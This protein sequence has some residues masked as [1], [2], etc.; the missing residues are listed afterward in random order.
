MTVGRKTLL[1]L[2]KWITA[3]LAA[4]FVIVLVRPD[5]L[6]ARRESPM[7][8]VQPSAALS[9]DSF[10]TAV[11]A[12]GPAVVNV[13]TARVI[14]ETTRP[15]GFDSL[16]TEEWP[17]VRRRVEASLGSGV[18][19]DAAGLVVT[20]HHVIDGAR[21]IRV[22]LSDGRIAVPEIVGADPETDLALLRVALTDLPVMPLGRSDG[23][24]VGDI[25]L[26][27]GNPLG[28]TQTVTQGI[29][30]ATGRGQI[31]TATFADFIQT[32]AA[33]NLGNSGGALVN[34]RGELVG[35]NTAILGRT[36]GTE[37]IGF[38]IPVNLVRG[39]VRE[40]LEHGRVRRGW[41][42]V[43]PRELPRERAAAIG[44][45]S[46]SGIELA[47]VYRN[48]PAYRGGLRPGDVITHLDGQ[49]IRNARDALSRVAGTQPGREVHVQGRRG[50]N[51]L[52]LTITV[53]ERPAPSRVRGG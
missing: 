42:G 13:Y 11:A 40:L 14:T 34:T 53:E 47:D 26:A 17:S 35:I 46:G 51:E 24:R 45:E 49:P 16:P 41:F 29:V 31:G 15:P 19:V 37:G 36:L 10:A 9:G 4:A 27:I 8:D 28:L 32:D 50:E 5:L 7:L 25:V 38:A 12:T 6:A 52:D 22:Q 3:G 39:V 30:S 1:F 23:V 2:G 43:V 48:G 21:E 20:N 33:I 44:L 18:I